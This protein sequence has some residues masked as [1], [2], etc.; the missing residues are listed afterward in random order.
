MKNYEPLNGGI[1]NAIYHL[2]LIYENFFQ[3]WSRHTTKE[4][5]IIII[6]KNYVELF[7]YVL[8]SEK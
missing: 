7:V 2:Y 8:G 5:V 3:Y 1:K 4:M 6:L